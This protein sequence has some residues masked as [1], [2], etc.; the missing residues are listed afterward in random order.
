MYLCSD[1]LRAVIWREG[2][3]LY[4]CSDELRAVIWPA[5]FKCSCAGMNFE[6]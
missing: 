5:A 6:R 4:L 3:Q 1:E 2:L